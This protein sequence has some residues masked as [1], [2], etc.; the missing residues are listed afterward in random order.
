VRSSG[1]PADGISALRG[2]IWRRLVEK[3]ELPE[4]SK[5]YAV[6]S[7]KLF[8]GKVQARVMADARP[9]PSF[10]EAEPTLEDVYF[11]VLKK[12]APIAPA[13]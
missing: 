1:V 5:K 11:S 9:D 4:C 8:A 13:A 10:D 12:P 2:R 7:T 6:V 3:A